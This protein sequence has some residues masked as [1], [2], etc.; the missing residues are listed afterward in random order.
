MADT[1]RAQ[2]RLQET[3]EG[4]S[5][6]GISYYVLSLLGYALK[7]L[8]DFGALTGERVLAVLVPVVAALV[9]VRMRRRRI[10]PVL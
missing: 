10:R 5:V 6:A 1:G 7:P 4:L 3:V 8:P 9:W 2:L